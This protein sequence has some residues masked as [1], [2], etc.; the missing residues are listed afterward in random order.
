MGNTPLM[1]AAAWNHHGIINALLAAGASITRTNNAGQTAYDRATADGRLKATAPAI[2]NSLNPANVAQ[3]EKLAATTTATPEQ[4]STPSTSTATAT[5][6]PGCIQQIGNGITANATTMTQQ[7]LSS[8]WTSYTPSCESNALYGILLSSSTATAAEVS[9]A[10]Q[11][12]GQWMVNPTNAASM[13]QPLPSVGFSTIGF[14][15]SLQGIVTTPSAVQQALQ[16]VA[17][18]PGFA[19]PVTA[20]LAAF[21]H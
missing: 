11:Q 13:L 2:Y 20:A 9:S 8:G 12:M 16:A 19:G 6:L 4:A 10:V 1:N 18:F 5:T 3:A 21:S 14:G 17:G 15:Q 7:L